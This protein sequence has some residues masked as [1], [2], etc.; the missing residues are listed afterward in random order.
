MSQKG[1]VKKV[2]APA[3]VRSIDVSPDGK[4]VRVTRMIKPFSYDVPV[5][6]FGSVEE[7]WDADGKLLAKVA[8]RADQPRRA[9]RH[10]AAP[11]RPRR[12][13]AAAAAQQQRQARDRVAP[14][15]SGLH[16]RRA[17]AARRAGERSGRGGRGSRPAAADDAGP[18]ARG[19]RGAQHRSARIASTSGPRRSTRPAGRSSTRT[20]PA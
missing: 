8:E 13:A 10:A 20:R 6:S 11:I 4:F 2:G 7:M 18:P 14:R 9:G 3:M 16:L 19:G 5:S 1:T 17:G 12:P 15:R